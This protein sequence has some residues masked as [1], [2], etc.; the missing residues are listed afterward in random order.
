[1]AEGTI[2]TIGCDLGDKVAELCIVHADGTESHMPAVKLTKAAVRKAF[3]RPRAHVVLEVGTNSRW[4]SELRKELG[5]QLTVAN[6]R[7][8]RLISESGSK[9]DRCDAELLARLGRADLKLLAPVHHRGMQAQADLAVAKSRDAL[10]RCRARLVNHARS[11]VKA[12]GG[13][14][15]S[16]TTRS[17]KHKTRTCAPEPLAPALQPIYRTIE[18]L[19]EE[20]KLHDRALERTARRLRI[21]AIVI[22]CSS[23]S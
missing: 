15:P 19:D 21:P 6:P 17:F 8:L 22:T 2:D 10:V 7:R 13:R 11:L 12:L 1:M 3:A 18:K 20:I 9:S 5:H 4:V 14:L 23:A 16:S